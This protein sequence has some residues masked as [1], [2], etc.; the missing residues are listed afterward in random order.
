MYSFSLVMPS[1][2][3]SAVAPEIVVL[4]SWVELNLLACHEAKVSFTVTV[5]VAEFAPVGLAALV[6]LTQ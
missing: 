2:S 6:T 3:G 5:A 4:A 1:P